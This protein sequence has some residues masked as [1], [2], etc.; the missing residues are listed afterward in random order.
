MLQPT[1]FGNVE[2]HENAIR[3]AFLYAHKVIPRVNQ[4]HTPRPLPT[5]P[6]ASFFIPAG[7]DFLASDTCSGFF[8]V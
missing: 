5:S 6:V 7:A 4:A 8:A 2:H 3:V 1:W